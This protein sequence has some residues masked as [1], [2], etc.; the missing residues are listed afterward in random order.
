MPELLRLFIAATTDLEAERAVIGRSI[1][2]LPVQIGIEI[3]RTPPLLPTFD[4]IFEKISNVDRVYFL[5]GNDITAPAGL[6][7]NLAW[8][9]ERSI[10][11]MR[12]STKPTPAAQEFCR[13]VHVPWVEFRSEAEL[14]KLMTL[15]LARLLKHPANRYGL[16]VLE[17]E[18]LEA[19]LRRLERKPLAPRAE[20]GGAE[21]GGVLLDAGHREPMTGVEL[22]E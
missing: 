2:A 14:V 6:E 16:T 15:D 22:G 20:L 11:P 19:Y 8:R 1:A 17:L 3:R 10:L 5:M 13:L 9:L 21:G 7:W 12:R 18:R 4:E